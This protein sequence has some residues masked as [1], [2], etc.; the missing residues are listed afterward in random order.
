MTT[1][2]YIEYISEKLLRLKLTF[3]LPVGTVSSLQKINI[4]YQIVKNVLSVGLMLPVS[5]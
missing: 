5:Y 2:P 3:S 4:F 1:V